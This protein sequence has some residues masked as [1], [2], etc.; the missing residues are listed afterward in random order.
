MKFDAS[1]NTILTGSNYQA[2][3]QQIKSLF[4]DHDIDRELKFQLKIA[5]Y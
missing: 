4:Y 1:S 5:A 3:E 2:A